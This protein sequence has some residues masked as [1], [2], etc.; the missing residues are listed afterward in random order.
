MMSMN[1][2][3]ACSSASWETLADPHNDVLLDSTLLIDVIRTATTLSPIAKIAELNEVCSDWYYWSSRALRQCTDLRLDVPC[4]NVTALVVQGSLMRSSQQAVQCVEYLLSRIDHLKQLSIYLSGPSIGML[5]DVLDVLLNSDKVQLE[6]IRVNGRRGGLRVERIGRLLNKCACTLRIA[7]KIGISEF[8]EAL[9]Q[10][11]TLDLER[12]S[13]NN[14]DLFEESAGMSRMGTEMAAAFSRISATRSSFS[15]RVRHLSLSAVGGFNA[16]IHPYNDFIQTTKVQSLRVTQQSGGLF[17]GLGLLPSSPLN[18][19]TSF[20]VDQFPNRCHAP[21]EIR[22]VFPSLKRLLV[23][24]L[25]LP[26]RDL[27]HAF[28]V[29]SLRVTQQSGGLFDGLGL[30]PSSPLN[31]VTSFEVDQFP[32]RCHAPSEIRTVFPS[33]KRL[34]VNSLLLPLRDLEHAF[35]YA[36]EWLTTFAD[37]ELIGV[38]TAEVKHDYGDPQ[39]A[40]K[41]R[42]HLEDLKHCNARILVVSSENFSYPAQFVILNSA[43]TFR[44]TIR[45][46][47]DIWLLADIVDVL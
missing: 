1:D 40:D 2:S 20:E 35:A 37:I 7:G 6:T 42:C 43:G 45:C 12:L 31:G 5:N 4:G 41:I 13:L 3:L 10:R 29:Q 26:L 18:G 44:F 28:A 47:C 8:E 9:R 15:L 22:T 24:S 33:L 17:D 46:L 25:L 30:L 23:N 19:V 21:S 34:L 14:Y 32:N 16:A 11:P 38:H 27:E 39:K 36:A